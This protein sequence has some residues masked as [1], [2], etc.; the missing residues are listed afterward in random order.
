MYI[1]YM[2][3]YVHEHVVALLHQS[4]R[5][6]LAMY[7]H[8]HSFFS[9][10]LMDCIVGSS[11]RQCWSYSGS[12][13]SLHRQTSHRSWCW[14]CSGS[15]RTGRRTDQSALGDCRCPHKLCG[16]KILH[17]SWYMYYK[18]EN[19]NSYLTSLDLLFVKREVKFYSNHLHHTINDPSITSHIVHMMKL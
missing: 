19:K 9:T 7:A 8:V 11:H 6:V 2:Y 12:L 17:Q 4:S 16:C 15:G 14:C 13:C 18:E 5:T 3:M 1:L 10:H